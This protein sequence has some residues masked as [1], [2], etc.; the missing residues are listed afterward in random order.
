MQ[1]LGD[2]QRSS[3]ERVSR[4]CGP[5]GPRT[6]ASVLQGQAAWVCPDAAAHSLRDLGQ[7]PSRS[8]PQLLCL[9]NGHRGSAGLIELC[10]K[11][12]STV[13]SAEDQGKDCPGVQGRSG[14]SS[15]DRQ[16]EGSHPACSSSP[17]GESHPKHGDPNVGTWDPGHLVLQ[18]PSTRT[19][20]QG[21]KSLV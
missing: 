11:F 19:C 10:G 7:T 4:L 18:P 1:C 15:P 17:P 2:L 6:A 21:W 3:G 16:G 8:Q 13:S 20:G 9:R 12:W 14:T 5:T